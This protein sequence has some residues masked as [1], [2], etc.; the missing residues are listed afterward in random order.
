MAHAGTPTDLAKQPATSTINGLWQAVLAAVVFFALVAGMVFVATNLAAKGSA[1]PA[2]D[3]RYDQI[4]GTRGAILMAP[5]DNSYNQVEQARNGFSLVPTANS[6]NQVEQ[7]RNGNSL[8]PA[9]HYPDVS[10]EQNTLAPTKVSGTAPYA[11]PGLV[12]GHRGAMI[13][14]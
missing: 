7:A 8:V 13:D 3:H 10:Y 11:H 1:V 6:S 4:E 9:V 5:A 12:K 2:A 14:Q